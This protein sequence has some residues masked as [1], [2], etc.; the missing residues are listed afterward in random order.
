MSRRWVW[1]EIGLLV[2]VGIII[3]GLIVFSFVS[4]SGEFG[5]MTLQD[6][7][8][9]LRDLLVILLAA[10]T[11]IG[12]LL[13]RLLEEALGR[14]VQERFSRLEGRYLVMEG[15]QYW[16]MQNLDK[17]IEQTKKA[18]QYDL[19]DVVRV[20]AMNNLAY[21]LA[22]RDGGRTTIE[23]QHEE[24]ARKLADKVRKGYDKYRNGYDNPEWLDTYIYVMRT[25]AKSEKEENDIKELIENYLKRPELSTIHTKLRAY[26]ARLQELP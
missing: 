18:L 20:R 23:W 19:E 10:I 21:Y 1:I 8:E 22:Q 26:L 24:E 4:F 16:H 6:K 25:Y 3:L 11:A 5:Q 15:F 9:L 12:L 7:Y 13:Y 17:A 2:L 14:K